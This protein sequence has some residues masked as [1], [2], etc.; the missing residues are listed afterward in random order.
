[1]VRHE[2]VSF[3]MSEAIKGAKGFLQREG[4]FFPVLYAFKKGSPINLDIDNESILNIK[5]EEDQ[6]DPEYIYRSVIGFRMT[7]LKDEEAIL[8]IS[9]RIAKEYNLDAVGLLLSCLFKESVGRIPDD[10]RVDP[11]AVKVLHACYFIRKN[12]HESFIMIPYLERGELLN[13]IAGGDEPKYDIT[14]MDSTWLSPSKKLGTK[15]PNPFK[16]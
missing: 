4:V 16:A 7:G 10:L 3:I 1:M 13:S 9:K 11:E 5:N 6:G 15:I 12:S 14:F 2:Q 8:A